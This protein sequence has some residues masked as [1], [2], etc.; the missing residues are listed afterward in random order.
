MTEQQRAL[1]HC[2]AMSMRSN[3]EGSIAA[4]SLEVR[5]K[6]GPCSRI[7]EHANGPRDVT[8]AQRTPQMK[9]QNPIR[10]DLDE[11]PR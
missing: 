9:L 5:E 3:A 10:N 1:K 7:L 11:P 2:S 6:L 8:V 4:L